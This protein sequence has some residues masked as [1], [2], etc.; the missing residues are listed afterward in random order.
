M[1]EVRDSSPDTAD[2]PQSFSTAPVDVGD[3]APVG[4]GLVGWLRWAWRTLTSMRTALVLLFLL[5]LA[6][7]PGSLLPQRGTNPIRVNDY[8]ANDPLKGRILDRLGFFDVFAAPFCWPPR[9]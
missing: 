6:S 9:W 4:I 3:G 1:T 2:A 5:A 7:V 8:L